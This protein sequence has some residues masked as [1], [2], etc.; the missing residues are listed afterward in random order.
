M[1][2]APYATGSAAPSASE[3][4]SAARPNMAPAHF[5]NE[6]R[7]SLEPIPL[8]IFSSATPASVVSIHSVMLAAA[9]Q[10][11]V[12]HA[13]ASPAVARRSLHINAMPLTTSSAINAI[14]I[15]KM[16]DTQYVSTSAAKSSSPLTVTNTSPQRTK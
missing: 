16:R 5:K 14:L 4:P 11:S 1:P 12:D 10:R 15:Q 9:V 13:D 2:L 8:H 3:S 7:Q 6:R